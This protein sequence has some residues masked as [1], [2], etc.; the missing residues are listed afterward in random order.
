MPGAPGD[1]GSGMIQV[2]TLSG[3]W[4][5]PPTHQYLHRPKKSNKYKRVICVLME[6]L[7]EEAHPTHL[8]V[9][10]VGVM[11]KRYSYE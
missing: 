9:G 8:M 11:V 1:P 2:S 6:V 7:P 10:G 4:L 3:K 5:H